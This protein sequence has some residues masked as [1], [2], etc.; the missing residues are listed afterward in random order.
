MLPIALGMGI[1]QPLLSFYINRRKNHIESDHLRQLMKI[2]STT[3]G[4]LREKGSVC[5]DLSKDKSSSTFHRFASKG[6]SILIEG[7]LYLSLLGPMIF[8]S[9]ILFSAI[10]FYTQS[11]IS[12][13]INFHSNKVKEEEGI[14]PK[15]TSNEQVIENSYSLIHTKS[16]LAQW[17]YVRQTI[18]ELTQN[19]FTFGLMLISAT[20]VLSGQYEIALIAIQFQTTSEAFKCASRYFDLSEK[21]GEFQ[22]STQQLLRTWQ[23]KANAKDVRFIDKDKYIKGTDQPN[24]FTQSHT[25]QTKRSI[26][27][28]R[29]ALYAILAINTIALPLSI[30]HFSLFIPLI[31]TYV[32]PLFLVIT[33][34]MLYYKICKRS[35]HVAVE[36]ISWKLVGY[37]LL[38]LLT[39]T[40]S[41]GV[42]MLLKAPPTL[43]VMYN[44]I[45]MLPIILS[46]VLAA[47]YL[48]GHFFY[49][50]SEIT[51]TF[52]SQQT[53]EYF[54]A[55]A[56]IINYFSKGHFKFKESQMIRPDEIDLAVYT[57]PEKDG[58]DLPR[59]AL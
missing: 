14:L 7:Y 49:D 16:L 50:I 54:I 17:K 44:W 31:L 56:K 2:A 10:A 11:K 58:Q 57:T 13:K 1:V 46:C 5:K 41:L 28:K 8:T 21:W 6:I 42:A 29:I 33:A 9:V 27:L 25:P 20:L 12:N 51:L 43:L 36:E 52:L 4:S 26:N 45:M 3:D 38:A 32:R 15:S 37:P 19:L 22:T 59:N 53:F 18:N 34:P 48:L 30:T 40:S 23:P 39:I 55:P 47:D 35:E 24:M